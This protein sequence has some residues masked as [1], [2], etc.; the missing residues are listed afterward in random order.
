MAKATKKKTAR[1]PAVR[2]TPK[3]TKGFVAGKPVSSKSLKLAPMP[4]S[5][6]SYR[7]LLDQ[8]E[9][10]KAGES[11]P[12]TVPAGISVRAFNNRLNSVISR[13]KPKAPKGCK[14]RKRAMEDGR[15][16]IMCVKA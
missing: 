8:M 3:A 10:L 4:R 11:I 14:F 16:A 7:P 1:K 2:K 5:D 9:K 6:T 13:Y 15:V 12:V